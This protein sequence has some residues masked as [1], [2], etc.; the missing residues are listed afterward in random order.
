MQDLKN[1]IQKR[2]KSQQQMEQPIPV[3]KNEDVLEEISASIMK[4][5]DFLV[6]T[7]QRSFRATMC[8]EIAVSRYF[9]LWDG[10]CRRDAAWRASLIQCFP[11][12][13]SFSP[14]LEFSL[15]GLHLYLGLK[16]YL[17]RKMLNP[18]GG[19]IS[20]PPT[21]ESFALKG[22]RHSYME[23]LHLKPVTNK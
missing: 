10:C 21:C 12:L 4:S 20:R 16:W 18:V 8:K 15:C 1:P 11:K 2:N 3:P 9:C 6:A 22:G 23:Q 19:C 13:M 5:W 7:A 17:T 14:F